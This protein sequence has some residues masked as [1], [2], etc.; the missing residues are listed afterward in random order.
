MLR[1][2]GILRDALGV[3]PE[4]SLP[5]SVVHMSEMMGLPATGVSLPI[6]VEALMEATGVDGEATPVADAPVA[7]GSSD[8]GNCGDEEVVLPLQGIPE[9]PMVQSEARSPRCLCVP[10]VCH[11]AVRVLSSCPSSL[12]R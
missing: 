12:V 4:L 11:C 10:R 9:K 5:Q 7:D 2:V 6:Q 8:C 1:A 3:P